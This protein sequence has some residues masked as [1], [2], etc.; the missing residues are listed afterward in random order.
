MLQVFSFIIFDFFSFVCVEDI[1]VNL[2][3]HK[4][5]TALIIGSQEGHIG[6]V[7]HLCKVTANSYMMYTNNF[8]NFE[9]NIDFVFC[10]YF[11]ICKHKDIKVNVQDNVGISALMI[12]AGFGHHA[13]VQVQF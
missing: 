7:E 11:Y 8:S 5:T 10:I 12:A 6:I 13:I 1:D 3:N 2:R 9:F 4:G